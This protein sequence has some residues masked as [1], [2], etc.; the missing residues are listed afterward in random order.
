VA[1][2]QLINHAK[3][4]N[5]ME[6]LFWLEDS[7]VGMT[8]SSTEWGYP[9]I[10]SLH[11]IGMATLVGVSLMLMFR[12]LGFAASIPVTSLASY[13]RIALGGFGLNLL[14]GSALFCGNASELFFNTAFR[15]KIVLV[16]TGLALSWWLVRICIRRSENVT[17]GHKLLAA[18]AT[19]TWVVAIIFGRLIGY[20]S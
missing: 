12:V 7:V 16:F 18:C 17:P 9:V 19:V 14:S 5:T 10:L 8:V 6:K 11:A 20:W 1:P 13:W 3:L 4:E 15:L 2:T